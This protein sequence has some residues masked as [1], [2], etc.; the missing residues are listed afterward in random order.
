ML[1]QAL[2][3]VTLQVGE[4]MLQQTPQHEQA[5]ARLFV[6]NERRV[7]GRSISLDSIG[8]LLLEEWGGEVREVSCSIM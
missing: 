6:M 5:P 8:N 2:A 4:Q 3:H 1:L 7:T